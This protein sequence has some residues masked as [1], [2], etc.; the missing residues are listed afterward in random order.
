MT[1]GLYKE[2]EVVYWLR[3]IILRLEEAE[4]KCA[5]IQIG[6]VLSSLLVGYNLVL[7]MTYN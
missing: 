1:M 6:M 7:F 2:L 3:A 4:E 5:E